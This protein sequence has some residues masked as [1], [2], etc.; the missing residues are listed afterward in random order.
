MHGVRYLDIRVGYYRSAKPVFWVNHGISRQQPLHSILQQVRDFVLET[1]EIV[2]FDV[3]EF[4]IGKRAYFLLQLEIGELIS[5]MLPSGFRKL[6]THRSLVHYIQ[7][8]IGDL[9]V[10]Y[11]LTWD[12]TLNNIWRSKRNI[13][14][15]YDYLKV[16]YEFPS[17]LWMSVQQRWGNVQS[18]PDLK[19][20]LAPAGREFVL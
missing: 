15:G 4:P 16:M 1:N 8:E 18:V 14:I 12:A 7:S 10:D 9:M 17:Q 19:R 13:I 5:V 2:I 20:Y 6:E 11:S 3:Q